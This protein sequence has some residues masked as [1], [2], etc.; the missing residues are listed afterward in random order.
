M[1]KPANYYS[2]E[3][4]DMAP[5]LP[6]QYSRVLEVG[7]AEG[8]FM[9]QV[10]PGVE[11]WGVEPKGQAAKVAA[12]KM[13]RVLVGNY[14]QVEDELPDGYFDLVICNDVVQ[15]MEDHDAFFDSV[16]RKLAPRGVLM[17]S[18]A[19]FRF[20][21]NVLEIVVHREMKYLDSGVL[22]RDHMRFFTMR[23]MKRTLEEHGFE[24]DK[25]GGLSSVW[26]M[27]TTTIGIIKKVFWI[28]AITIVGWDSIYLQFGFRARLK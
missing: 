23:S 15:F 22:D 16:K 12:S 5:Y 21:E 9:K 2:F 4:P 20:I 14:D 19:N 27:Q 24:V 17:G 8:G 6:G 25:I 28:P 18:T 1:A 7:C 11:Y 26:E 13:H 3:R 10:K